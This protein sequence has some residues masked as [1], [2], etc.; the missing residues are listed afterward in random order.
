MEIFNIEHLLLDI[1]VKDQKEAFEA[2]ATLAEKL[3]ITKDP[4]GLVDDF[5]KREAISTT[6]MAEAVAIPHAMSADFLK[7]AIIVA[8]FKNG[9]DWKAVGDQPVKVAFA[10]LIPEKSRG[11]LHMQYLQNIAM[12]LMDSNFNNTILQSKDKNEIVETITKA[13]ERKDES[14]KQADDN[15]KS[16]GLIIGVSSC[17]T[18]VAHTYMAREA[19]EKHAKDVGYDVWIETQGQTGQEHKLT[20]DMI[21]KADYVVIASDINV[22]LDRFVGKKLYMTDTNEAIN[23]PVKVLEKTINTSQTRS[24]SSDADNT[25]SAGASSGKFMKHF[26]NGVSHMIPFIVFSGILY[27]VLNAIAIGVGFVDSANSTQPLH[28]AL[29]AADIGFSVF[30][31]IMGGYIAVSIAGRAAMAPGFIATMVAASPTL[32]VAYGLTWMKSATINING[33]P[34]VISGIGLGII[35]AIVMGFAAGHL[36]NLFN[37]LKVH[38]IVK[39]IMP[40]IIIPVVCTCMLVFPFL[41]A[42]SGIMGCMMNWIGAG[43][44]LA[45]TNPG[46]RIAIGLVLGAM[47]G[48]DMGGPINKIAVATATT[49]IPVDPS[50]MGAVAAAIPIAPIGCGLAAT[51]FGRKVFGD[52]DKGLG[53]SALTLG[54][55][56]ISEGAIPFAARNLKQTII[57]NVVG[58]ALAGLLA[59]TFY[60]GGH[61]GMWG[62]LII[63]FCVG[64]YCGGGTI[65]Y[66]VPIPFSYDGGFGGSAWQNV[67]ISSAWYVLAIAVAAT[68]HGI[69]YTILIRA[70]QGGGFKQAV[71][72]TFKRNSKNAET[73]ERVSKFDNWYHGSLI[74][75]NWFYRYKVLHKKAIVW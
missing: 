2:I 52:M 69:L 63:V 66:S 67:L 17:A 3:G 62:G 26:L 48:F 59:A 21:K 54:F 46:G 61:V 71:K 42:F 60:C 6:G 68:I 47:V 8:R 57:A 20:D 25:F 65:Q 75:E 29:M 5:I 23:T 53:V 35:A 27:A 51:V 64:V 50:L 28:F 56:G 39:P 14:V 37:G 30:T 10:L 74:Q 9:I 7:P 15:S 36:V 73:P 1:D 43:L 70:K 38:K 16:K 31:A 19:L 55:M 34:E 72:S 22:E 32:Y 18:G 11:T 13:I 40:L 44:A 24:S 58:S 41:F 33:A 12:A 45:G 4:K 49:L